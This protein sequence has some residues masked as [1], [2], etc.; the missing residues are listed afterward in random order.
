MRFSAIALAV[1]LTT[2]AFA[3]TQAVRRAVAGI[4]EADIRRRVNI[5][6]HDSMGGRNTPSRGLELVA[7]YVASEFRRLGLKPGGDSGSFLQRYSIRQLRLD[8]VASTLTLRGQEGGQISTT[9]SE[10]A[11]LLFG[12]HPGTAPV[13]LLGGPLDSLATRGA[14]LAGKT[15]VW[16]DDWTRPSGPAL[17]SIGTILGL[18]PAMVIVVA[19][20]DSLFDRYR[21]MQTTL[22]TRV[23]DAATT[24]PAL[25]LVSQRT[26]AEQLPQAIDQIL[27]VRQAKSLVVMEVPGWEATLELKLDLVKETSAP[28]TVG[29]L[30]GSDS[31]LRQE[32]LVYSAHMDHIGTAGAE[33]AGCRA[34]GADSVCNG[35]DDD[36]SG[37]VGIIELAEAFARKGARPKRS[38]IFLTVSGEEHGLWGSD[39]FVQHPP[40]PLDRIVANL[41]A[42]MIGRNWPDS[43]VVIGREHSDLGETLGRVSAAHPELRMAVLDDRWP[44]ESFYTRSDHYHFAR[45]GVPVLFFFN[46]VHPDYH[47][48]SDSPERLEAEKEARIV[49]L[50][51]YLGWDIGNAPARPKWNQASYDKYV[52]GKE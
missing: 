10:G 34:Q 29:I 3:Q 39:Y 9:L 1:A 32:Y 2:P 50:M 49:R 23:G 17:N 45:H 14:A 19:N 33:G 51:F 8:P 7:Q 37:T 5:V 25:L 18:N 24:R 31:A 6:A 52:T 48:A 30:E 26:I 35:A 28:N 20:N 13:V 43:I 42:D 46:G 16:V 11:A 40:V 22:Q 27:P 21:Q 15:V 36:A 4:T 44:D 47:Q 41:N 12:G 38:I